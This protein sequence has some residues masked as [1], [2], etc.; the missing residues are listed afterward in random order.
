MSWNPSIDD[1]V[2]AY[3]ELERCLGSGCSNFLL[4]AG[5][6]GTG[7][8]DSG[9]AAGTEYGYR[10]RAVDDAGNRSQYSA[11]KSFTTQ[12]G[13]P[14]SATRINVGS[15]AYTDSA[16]NLWSG[17]TGSNTGYP[18][19]VWV[20]I[21]GTNDPH[22]FQTLRWD[23][24]PAPELEYNFV[25]PSG[26]YQVNLLFAETWSGAF[27]VGARIF[28][29]RLNGVTAIPGLD[30][31]AEVGANAALIKTASVS[32]PDGSL[33]IEF[34]RTVQNPFV[35]G[36]EL[37]PLPPPDAE[38]P[39]A[40]VGFSVLPVSGTEINLARLE[41]TD[42]VGIGGYRIER[43][44]GVSCDAFAEI[45]TSTTTSYSDSGLFSTSTYGYRVRA[46]DT[47]NSLG[48]YSG[49]TYATTLQGATD[50]VYYSYDAL[51][52]LSQVTQ[53]D[54][55]TIT[56]SYDASGNITSKVQQGQ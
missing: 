42:N 37:I 43:C 45:G 3:Y 15:G 27:Q 31:F 26:Q 47:S 18:T 28:D 1:G 36:I 38:A 35:N 49:T 8:S 56:Y 16:S 39:T 20:G 2:V 33:K 32:V 53:P 51:G 10:V 29:I 12:D 9:L 6:T 55:T 5:P 11:A 40:P 50:T 46:F 44:T 14:A 7:F 25:V 21:A 13:T 52:R 41:A 30:I 24:V 17:D 54:G 34:L 4:I 22:L 19:T 23:D 48:P